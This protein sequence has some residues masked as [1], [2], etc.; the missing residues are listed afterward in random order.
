METM[1]QVVETKK[2]GRGRPKGSINPNSKRQQ[3]L[4]ERAARKAAKEAEQ[5]GQ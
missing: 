3:M 1:E 5:A 2:R 4:R